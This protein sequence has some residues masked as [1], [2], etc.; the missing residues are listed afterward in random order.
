MKTYKPSYLYIKTHNKTGLKYF[1]KTIQDPYIYEGSGYYWESHINVHGY[2]VTTELLN[3]GNPY[4]DET[5]F[6]E[7][8]MEFSI[9]NNIVESS[10]WA[11]LRLETGD[12]GD[13]SMCENYI[14]SI[15]NRDMSGNNN[16]MWGK[17][18]F[19]KGK[20]YEEIYGGEKAKE[21][22][23][24]RVEVATGRKLSEESLKKM[25]NSIS[26]ST[27]GILKGSQKIV[28]CIHCGKTGGVS[29]MNRWHFTNC[30]FKRNNNENS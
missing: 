7:A 23:K 30:K 19:A 13:T 8:A 29:L 3:H 26:K 27:K 6:K 12:G 1:G 9:K 17:T 15:A 14:N 18:S 25:A 21:L 28:T 20:T 2:D 11:N 5:E 22:K 10:E 16:P 24:M 4:V